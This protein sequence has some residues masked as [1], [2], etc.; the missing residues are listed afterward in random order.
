MNCRIIGIAGGSGSGKTTL[1]KRLAKL[2]GDRCLV[3]SSDDYYRRTDELAA[4]QRA[5]LNFDLPDSLEL[6]LLA[7]HLQQLRDGTEVDIPKYCFKT[8]N[9]LDEVNRVAS[10]EIVLVE[11][12]LIF[13]L[14]DLRD[15]MDLRVFVDADD[16]IRFNRR[17]DR[18]VVERQRTPE[19]VRRQWGDTVAP[20]YDKFVGPTKQ[21]AHL[22]V[23]TNETCD[24]L[25]DWLDGTPL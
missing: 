24:L 7:S 12:V 1:C 9:R 25:D 2:W 21:Y 5:A 19:S 10:K 11:G 6:D 18:D 14:P 15:A 8:H 22:V 17:R 3:I 23:N 4:E 20:M 13:A 16:T